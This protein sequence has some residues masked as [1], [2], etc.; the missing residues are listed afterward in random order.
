MYPHLCHF[1]KHAQGPNQINVLF[2]SASHGYN[3][4]TGEMCLCSRNSSGVTIVMLLEPC[5]F[6]KKSSKFTNCM[7]TPGGSTFLNEP[8]LQQQRPMMV[9]LQ[10]F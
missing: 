7:Y 5:D 4:I 2:F 6:F 1:L 3:S 8:V 10:P 9:N